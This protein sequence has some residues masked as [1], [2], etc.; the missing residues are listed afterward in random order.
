MLVV[1]AAAGGRRAQQM[2]GQNLSCSQAWTVGAMAAFS[3]AIEAVARSNDPGIGG[4]TLQVLA[5]VFEHRRVFGGK[6]SKIVN[7]SFE[8]G[9]QASAP[10]SLAQISPF[11]LRWKKVRF[12]Q[13]SR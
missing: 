3:N 11:L 10:S 12:G 7:H 13:S 2:L 8:P 6:G 4:G 5:E 1:C 9:V